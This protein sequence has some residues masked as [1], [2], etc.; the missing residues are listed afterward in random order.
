MLTSNSL[1]WLVVAVSVA[2]LVAVAAACA[3]ETVEV[4]GETVVVK[5]EVIKTIEVPGETVV[6]EVI[7]EVQVPGET[8]VVEKVVTETVEVPG[9]TV[10]V[11]KEV[12]KTVEVPG[13][14]VTVEVVK[15]V[16]V[17]GET[18]VVEKEVVK[19]VEVPGQTVVV[20]KE[21]VK[22]VEVPGETVVIEKEVIK[23]VAGPERVMVKE[24]RAGYVTDPA[25]GKAV[26]KPQYGGTLNAAL[27]WM[28]P[29]MDT[30]YQPGFASQIV[31]AVIERPALL[32]WAIDRDVWSLASEYR[33]PEYLVPHLADSWEQPDGLTVIFH[34]R[35]GVHW[36]DKPPMNG[37][38]LTADDFV[39]NYHRWL[40]LGSGF[41]EPSGGAEFLG[42]GAI[43]SITATDKY[44]VEFKLNEDVTGK[45]FYLGFDIGQVIAASYYSDIYPPEVIEEHGD[46]KDWRN[47]VGTGPFMIDDFV[48]DSS[49]T[50]KKNPNYWGNDP[51][52]PENRLPYIDE[53]R[54]LFLPET[55]TRMAALRTG[56]VDIIAKGRVR[57]IDQAVSLMQTNPEI[58]LTK[59]WVRSN[60]SY[61]FIL[62]KEPFGDLRVRQAMNMALDH[63]TINATYFKG[64]GNWEPQGHLSSDF[65]G[66]TTPFAEWPEEIKKY[67]TYDPEAAEALLDAAGHERDANGIRFKTVMNVTEGRDPNYQELAAGYWRQIGVQVEINRLNTAEAKAVRET[68]AMEGLWQ[69]A[70]AFRADPFSHYAQLY[71]KSES[72]TWRGIAD[73]VYDALY[74]AAEA[75]QAIGDI[76]EVKRLAREMELRQAEM[77]WGIWGTEAPFFN[78]HWPWVKGF[79]GEIALGA[80][81]QNWPFP[82]LWIDHELKASMGY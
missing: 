5:E 50:Y 12:V 22:T 55:A 14:T 53:L 77:H 61:G 43:E 63:E 18:V 69:W 16:M 72:E 81:E 46:A 17:P 45:I 11:E 80:S 73:P 26:T 68:G 23:T 56:K 71:S 35:K 10:V 33:P 32:D 74:E 25:T 51:K 52:Y 62:N 6:K 39:Y 37:R 57:S 44:T 21:V 75:A 2:M 29:Q 48:M 54:A 59:V 31:S 15:E 3:G 7:K 40:G 76:E 65:T 27:T 13:E 1:R 9:E 28:A 36:H 41:T 47:L 70:M 60:N 64:Y 20:E 19:T 66:W 58:V 38:E 30:F 42:Y 24:V 67:W 82:Y 4:P 49:V 79:N 78:A 34:V 8:V